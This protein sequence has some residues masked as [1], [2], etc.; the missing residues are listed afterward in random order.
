MQNVKP[1]IYLK[2]ALFFG[3]INF[4][5]SFAQV[6]LNESSYKT[7]IGT[8]CK[9][10]IDGGCIIKTYCTLSFKK[11]IVNISYSAEADCTPKEREIFYEKNA[12]KYNKSEL[13]S[14]KNSIIN[15]E[16]FNDYG[17]FIF[18]KNSLI[19]KKEVNG[20]LENLVFEKI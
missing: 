18:T 5:Y 4:S 16:N 9:E 14:E 12:N 2:I 20:K 3:I 11:N 15:I 7:L 10:M 19:G 17:D 13:W 6:N 1:K 8:A